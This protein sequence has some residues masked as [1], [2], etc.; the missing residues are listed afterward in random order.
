MPAILRGQLTPGYYQGSYHLE[1]ISW[2]RST[3]WGIGMD[4]TLF[5]GLTGSLDYYN[6]KTTGII[7]DVSAPAEFALGAYKDNI[8]ALRNQGVELSLAYA[9][10]LNKDWS[11]NVGA[12]FAYN[13]NKILNLGDGTEYIGSGNRR[14]AV[15]QQYNSFFMYKATGKFFNSQ[16]EADDYTA[17][18]GNPFGRKFMAGDL[19]Y[20]D[21]NGDGKLDS[22]DRIYTKHTDIPAITYGFNLGATWKNIDLSMIGR[23][24]EQFLI[25]TTVRFLASSLAMPATH[26]HYGK[27]HGQR[28]ITMLNSLVSSRQETVQAT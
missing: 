1:T 14:T 28:T 6:R 20:E 9:K 18:Y 21:T 5:G 19:I 8:G 15:G 12:N 3:T 10:Q 13:K 23:V 4:F 11:I 2:E 7:M 22:N 26:Q 16:Q 25:S 24:L 17:K 27:T